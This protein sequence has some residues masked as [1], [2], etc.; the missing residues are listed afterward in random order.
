MGLKRAFP[1]GRASAIGLALLVLAGCG[2]KA[3]LTRLEPPD[4]SAGK[5]E[6][7]A[8]RDDERR[9]VAAGLAVPAHARPTRV[10]DLAEKLEARGAD[11]FALPPEGSRGGA[12]AAFPGDAAPATAAEK[13]H[14]D[15]GTPEN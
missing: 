5:A 14:P 7:K 12:P 15:Q 3:P 11:P 13:R 6:R 9:R 1:A 10:D 8:A 2:Y 4:P